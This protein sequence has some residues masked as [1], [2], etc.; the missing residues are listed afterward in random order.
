MIISADS[1]CSGGAGDCIAFAW[2]A[3]ASKATSDPIAM[4]SKDPKKRIIIPMLGQALTDEWQHA[5]ELTDSF[6]SEIKDGGSKPRWQ[7]W[8]DMLNRPDLKPVPPP[9]IL[10]DHDLEW[11]RTTVP[12]FGKRPLVVLCPQASQVSRQWPVG[13]WMD[14]SEF[15][16][17]LGCTVLAVYAGQELNT[18]FRHC[19]PDGSM[20]RLAA[21]MKLSALVVSGDS[22]G[23]HLAVTCGVPTLGLFGPTNAACVMGHALDRLQW[24]QVDKDTMP[25]TGCNGAYEKMRPSCNTICQSLSHLPVRTV[26][27]KAMEMIR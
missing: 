15:L 19:L 16:E 24:L 8:T 26:L 10:S 6:I 9:V 21:L 7:Y 5:L 22:F 27:A 12:G 17:A 13:Y 4:H 20:D 14:L 23:L 3:E 1:R 2:L 11:V 25:C 18:K